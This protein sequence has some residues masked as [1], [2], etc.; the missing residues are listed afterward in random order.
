MA[1]FHF[2]TTLKLNSKISPELV[3]QEFHCHLCY[4]RT[5]GHW[6]LS[7]NKG[8]YPLNVSFPFSKHRDVGRTEYRDQQNWNVYS[9]P[10]SHHAWNFSLPLL[11]P[12]LPFA[13]VAQR[14]NKHPGSLLYAHP[15]WE[16]GTVQQGPR[17]AEPAPPRRACSSPFGDTTRI[18]PGF[19]QVIEHGCE[20]ASQCKAKIKNPWTNRK[21]S[22]CG[23]WF[24][25][26]RF[27]IGAGQ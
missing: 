8:Y 2:R 23:L 27:S 3:H 11:S 13:A 9:L 25:F 15:A 4:P 14:I 5:V 10:C 1:L 26:L 18:A 22:L 16:S 21:N 6:T 24:L 17:A 12:V 20:Q 19:T 7:L